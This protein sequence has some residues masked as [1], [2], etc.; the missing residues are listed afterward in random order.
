MVTFTASV[1]GQGNGERGSNLTF[2]RLG[3]QLAAASHPLGH[4]SLKEPFAQG[5][6]AFAH[7]GFHVLIWF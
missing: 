6:A 5:T 4:H 2:G 7:L 1:K 3:E